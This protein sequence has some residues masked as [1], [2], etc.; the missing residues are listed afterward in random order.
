MSKEITEQKFSDSYD[1]VVIGAGNGG[2]TAT[3]QLAKNGVKVLLLEQHNLPGGF[4]T[5]FVR[6]R[7]EFETS[8]HQIDSYGLEPK[9]GIRRMFEEKFNIDTEFLS[10]P[11]AY[12]LIINDPEEKLDVIMPFGIENFINA[13]EKVVPG[14][15]ESIV[16]F[17]KVAEE[18]RGAFGYFARSRG[19]P[20][21][22]VLIKDFSNFLKTAP[23]S[24]DEVEDALNIPDKAKQ[25][26]N[27]YW[28]FLG[29]PTNRLDFT[30]FALMVHSFMKNGGYIPKYRSHEYTTALDAKTGMEIWRTNKHLHKT[31]TGVAVEF[32][33]V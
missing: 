15:K 26:L 1:A 31:I 23:S 12:R 14:S 24:V 10:V 13:I 32:I 20:D 27:A 4:A 16:N 30:I 18:T 2:L 21:Q 11:E 33:K 25:I 7:F 28:A 3:A 19:K 17:F 8:L 9:G 5:S 29:I 22:G 6:G